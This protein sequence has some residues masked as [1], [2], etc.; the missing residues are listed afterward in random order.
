MFTKRFKSLWLL[1]PFIVAAVVIGDLMLGI[2]LAPELELSESRLNSNSIVR[3][4]ITRFRDGRTRF[5]T[6]KRET[7][8]DSSR[9]QAVKDIL[10]SI[11]SSWQPLARG[12]KISLATSMKFV[13]VW[14]EGGET[15]VGFFHG[16][17]FGGELVCEYGYCKMNPKQSAA[18]NSALRG[19]GE[20]NSSP[21]K[22]GH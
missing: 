1:I 19:E 12:V 15:E 20:L 16:G 4:E 9:I 5:P 22:Q 7:M 2:M 14:D 10:K 21:G 13:C 18:L 17:E 3:I 11:H 6:P 8:T